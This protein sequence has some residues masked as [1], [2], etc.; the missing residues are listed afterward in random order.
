MIVLDTDHLTSLRYMDDP[1]C[2]T[3]TA[4]LQSA[5]DQRVATTVVT[6]EEQMRGWLA[7]IKRCRD[8]QKQGPAYER[9]AS[10]V[11]FFQNWEILPFDSRAVEEFTR[12]RKRRI[13]IGTQDLKI[14]SITLVH[15]ATLLTANLRDFGKVPGLRVENWVDEVEDG[16]L[17]RDDQHDRNQ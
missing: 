13:R 17:S 7:A 4:R 11:R 6:L 9:L 15:D 12:L 10:L 5:S 3:L 1:R 8:V 2:A 16:S 14:A